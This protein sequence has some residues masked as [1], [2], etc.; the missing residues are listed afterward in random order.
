MFLLD[1]LTY[2][3]KIKQKYFEKENEHLY[4]EFY[5]FLSRGLA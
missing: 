5:L 2:Y 3:Y 4:I 1:V